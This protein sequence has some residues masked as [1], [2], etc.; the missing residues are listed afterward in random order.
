MVWVCKLCM[1]VIKLKITKGKDLAQSFQ[2]WRKPEYFGEPFQHFGFLWIEYLLFF[3]AWVTQIFFLCIE[4]NTQKQNESHW[5]IIYQLLNIM[6]DY[7][8][9]QDE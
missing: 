7:K 6:M 3:E 8:A 9:T 5:N 2:G 4:Y 1:L